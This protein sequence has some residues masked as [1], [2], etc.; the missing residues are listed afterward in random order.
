[1]GGGRRGSRGSRPLVGVAQPEAPAGSRTASPRRRC[2]CRR[3]RHHQP[4]A[5]REA[6]ASSPRSL[7][8]V[9]DQPFAMRARP[10]FRTSRSP[11][12]R[13]G[14]AK[15]DQFGAGDEGAVARTLHLPVRAVVRAANCSGPGQPAGIRTA[16]RCGRSAWVKVSQPMPSR[17]LRI[18][19]SSLVSIVLRAPIRGRL[20]L[21]GPPAQDAR[22][23]DSAANRLVRRSRCSTPRAVLAERR[24]GAGI[25]GGCEVRSSCMAVPTSST[26]P[27]AG[28]PAGRAMP[29]CRTCPS[30]AISRRW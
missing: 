18:S 5:H 11:S 4:P 22:A 9:R 10:R 30:S 19:C 12:A 16:A 26:S 13:R 15:P 23:R 1:M 24:R 2:G 3:D 17:T 28:A 8:E 25:L 21:S 20:S 29:R 14:A 6:A 7:R 27:V